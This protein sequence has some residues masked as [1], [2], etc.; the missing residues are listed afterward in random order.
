M[1]G[2]QKKVS[3]IDVSVVV[4]TYKQEKYIAMTLDSILAQ[5]FSGTIEVLVGDD[6]SP[7]NTGAIVK[8]YGEKYPDIIKPIVRPKNLGAF[9]NFKDLMSKA[10]GKYIAIIEGDDYWINENKLQEQFEFM[11]S[12][13]DYVATF[14]QSIIVNENNER[15]EGWEQYITF[16]G[17]GEYTIEDYQNYLLPGQTASSFY[18]RDA[19]LKVYDVV[20]AIKKGKLRVFFALT[21]RMLVLSI[22]G[23]GRVNKSNE[24]YSAYRYILDPNSNSWSSQNDF[25]SFRNESIFLLT[26]YELEKI[27]K[28]VGL[29]LNFDER[30][31]YEFAVIA[32]KKGELN[33]FQVMA[34]RFIDFVTCKSKK[35]FIN[36]VVERKRKYK[37]NK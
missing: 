37:N 31:K 33:F 28:Y 26:I 9:K 2:F 3:N 14:G 32:D 7:D 10:Q 5:K 29:P 6:C 25:F 16:A 4:A 36:F 20:T 15:Q 35:D 22:L 12:H 11:E 27:A 34:L 8:E 24:Y 13:P 30:R 21:D 23:A 19:F 18:R 17:E 1:K